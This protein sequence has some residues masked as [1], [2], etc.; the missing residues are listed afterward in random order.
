M[1]PS[2][3][4]PAAALPALPCNFTLHSR[5]GALLA[6]VRGNWTLDDDAVR[7]QALRAAGSVTPQQRRAFER[8]RVRVALIGQGQAS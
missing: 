4:N 8:A 6:S 3:I 1:Q 2:Q 5:D 7:T